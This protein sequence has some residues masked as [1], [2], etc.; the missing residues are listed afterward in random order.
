MA[1]NDL[2]QELFG[3]EAPK[4]KG[5]DL[6][7]EFFPQDAGLWNNLKVGVGNFMLGGLKGKLDPISGAAQFAMNTVNAMTGSSPLQSATTG[8]NNLISRAEKAYQNATPGSVAAGAGR[9]LGNLAQPPMGTPVEGASGLARTLSAARTGAIIGGSQPVY[10]GDGANTDYWTPKAVQVA[11]GAGAGGVLAGAGGVAGAAYNTV[12]PIFSP[13]STVGNQIYN[14]LAKTS[15]LEQARGLPVN[16]DGLT[17]SDPAGVLARLKAATQLVPGSLPTT[18]Q[19]AGSPELVMAAKALR[20]NPNYT[21]AYMARESANNS[22]RLQAV[23]NVAQTP[24]ALQAAIKARSA[25]ADPLYSQ[26]NAQTIPIDDAL[27]GMLKTPIGKDAAGRAKQLAENEEQVFSLKQPQ[28]EQQVP[29]SIIGADGSP[30]S[31]MT[32]PAAPGSMSGLDAN[33]IK[34]AMDAMKRDVPTAGFASHDANALSSLRQRYV[35]NLD[36][37]FPAFQQARQAYAEGS[38]PVNTM[39]A[40]QDLQGALSGGAQNYAGDVAPTLTKYGGKLDSIMGKQNYPIDPDAM[41]AL[42]AV[43][44]DLQR[45][46]ISDSVPKSGSDTVW[47]AQAPNWLSGQLFGKSMDGNSLAGRG[48]SAIGGFF[49]GGAMG[50]AGGAAAAQKIGSVLGGRVNSQLQDAMMNPEVF[51]KLLEEAIAR[52]GGGILGGTSDVGARAATSGVNG[53][54]S[55]GGQ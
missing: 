48:L 49:S 40:G 37:N 43:R 42:Q 25:A 21:A 32:I 36:D 19:I 28:A 9:V 13:S 4:T 41:S 10:N 55:P 51:S 5:R 29:S 46:S 39:Q 15:K 45:R 27:N 35:G 33:R 8:L 38:V 6:S 47:N 16:V 20:N 30:L 50:A 17:G 54:L 24:E 22:A 3:S 11:A 44:Q 53:L 1:G 7:T 23:S 18:E 14:N 31:T 34:M 52:N 2:S 12:R 26:F